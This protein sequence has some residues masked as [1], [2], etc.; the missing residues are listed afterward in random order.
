MI[1][2]QHLAMFC[3]ASFILI[4][5]P[6]PNFIYI[7]TRG[8]TQ[9]RHAA[10][11]SSVG[12]GCGVVIH[13][14]FAAVGLSIL[15]QSSALAFSIV[16]YVGALYLIYLG[17]KALVGKNHLLLSQQH[18]RNTSA[19]LIWQSITASLT[20][21]KTALFF[22]TFLPQFVA[23]TSGYPA[24]QMLF[25]GCIYMLFTV[26]IYGMLA[27]FSGSI[28]NWLQRAP[29]L[30]DRFRWLTCSVFIG[31]GIWAAVPDHR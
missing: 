21:P 17:V 25:L 26:G 19:K 14:L 28:G 24:T 13:T 23:P 16:K 9:G 5:T 8:I 15:L 2:T 7:L 10:L 29:E 22:L 1:T 3:V 18:K 27:Y 30:A 31:L 6:G 12:L 20:N 4:L 11:V